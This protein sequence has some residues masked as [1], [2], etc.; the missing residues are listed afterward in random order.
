MP[1]QAISSEVQQRNSKYLKKVIFRWVVLLGLFVLGV[2]CG[3]VFNNITRNNLSSDR[4]VRLKGNYKFTNPLLECD[5]NISNYKNLHNLTGSLHN[6]LSDQINMKNATEAAVYYRDLNNG[7]WFGINEDTLFSPSSLLKVPVM[8]AY[9]K[10]AEDDPE[11]LIKIITDDLPKSED[12]NIQDYVP[13]QQI[14]L[15]SKYTILELIRR[16]II[17]SDN[18][19]TNLLYNSIDNQKLTKVFKDLGVNY[20]PNDQTPDGVAISIKSYSSFFRILYNSSYLSK[21][22]SEKA[23]EIL[24]ES[25]FNDGI[26]T[27]IPTSIP[28]AH[29]FGERNN[30]D[31]G[32]KQLHDCGIVYYPK[33]PYM[34]CVMTRG[35]DFNQL[36]HIIATVSAMTYA[37]VS[38]QQ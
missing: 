18:D 20:K 15:G 24:S 36:A 29:K 17:Y 5:S 19:A 22:M 14:K 34:I 26:R 32:I 2:G 1:E 25:A 11:I 30:L 7:P 35:S 38:K 31:T 10:L 13:E 27:G 3:F 8:I 4:E 21:D 12:N 37:E 33:T 9:F 6:Y 16:M 23:L 28:V